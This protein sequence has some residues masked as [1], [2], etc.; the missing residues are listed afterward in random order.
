MSLEFMRL[1][2]AAPRGAH[3][4]HSWTGWGK[5][6]ADVLSCQKW[7]E[8]P[9]S[10]NSAPYKVMEMG[11]KILH[12]GSPIG[13]TS[14]IHCLETHLR[15]P[16]YSSEA[17]YQVLQ[18]DGKMIW[19][20]IPGS[21]CGQR[22]TTEL[23]EEARYYKAAKAEGLR[24]DKVHLGAGTLILMD[25]RNYWDAGVKVFSRDPSVNLI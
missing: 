23:N 3:V 12:F 11:G 17:F 9:F 18:P 8:P 19:K 13:R 10:D 16:G 5:K 6:A 15:L 24:I 1:F 2:P 25:A 14:F 7:D 20:M 21:Y 22:E 4:S